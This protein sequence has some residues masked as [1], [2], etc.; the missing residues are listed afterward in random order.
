MPKFIKVMMKSNI[1]IELLTEFFYYGYYDEY[2]TIILLIFQLGV[3]QAAMFKVG[4]Y[5]I[6]PEIPE[7]MSDQAKLFIGR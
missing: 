5:K 4:F 3:P 6:H 1:L 7:S 2:V